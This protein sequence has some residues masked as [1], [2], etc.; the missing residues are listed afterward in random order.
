L[1]DE[2]SGGLRSGS[3]NEVSPK[4]PSVEDVPDSAAMEDRS[5]FVEIQK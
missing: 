5:D 4:I 3:Q 1:R 2:V